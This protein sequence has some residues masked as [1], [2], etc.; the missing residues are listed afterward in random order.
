MPFVEQG[1]NSFQC[2]CFACE[3]SVNFQNEALRASGMA[4]VPLLEMVQ[5]RNA[6][7]QEERLSDDE[8]SY[9]GDPLL[10][11]DSQQQGRSSVN[12]QEVG[13]DD[14]SKVEPKGS[15]QQGDE[16]DDLLGQVLD[17]PQH[18]AVVDAVGNG[19]VIPQCEH[20]DAVD[21]RLGEVS[22]VSGVELSP[23]D[24][25]REFITRDDVTDGVPDAPAR[26][27]AMDLGIVFL[28]KRQIVRGCVWNAGS[29]A[30]GCLS[31]NIAMV[32]CICCAPWSGRI[33]VLELSIL[34]AVAFASTTGNDWL[35]T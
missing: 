15:P 6:Q 9:Q 35:V 12:L 33:L 27:S 3:Y 19:M 34:V 10:N 16:L 2:V 4:E 30:G 22:I 21:V 5:I 20:Q 18:T 32:P 26:H 28:K 31:A 24:E 23:V 11:V 13:V 25:L 8:V 17:P 1:Y 29:G 7:W 14:D